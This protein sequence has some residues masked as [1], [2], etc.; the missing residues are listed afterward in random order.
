MKDSRNI[1]CGYGI[2]VWAE[3]CTPHQRPH[4]PAGWVLPTGERTTDRERAQKVAEAI[5][6]ILAADKAKGR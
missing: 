6:L 4:V 3:A 2:I 5:H 1:V